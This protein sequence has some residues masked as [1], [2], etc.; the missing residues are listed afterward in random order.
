[1]RE[2]KLQGNLTQGSLLRNLM[3]FSI[4][5]LIACFLQTFYGLADLYIIGQ[6]HGASSITAVSVGSQVTH[7]LTVVIVGLAMG[8]T[9]TISRA[10]GAGDQKRAGCYIAHVILCSLALAIVL[11][12]GL[13]LG[14]DGIIRL[15]S[16]PKE[17]LEETREYLTICFLGTIFITAYNCIS[18]IFRGLGDSKRPMFFVAIAG[19]L[20]IVLD[21]YFIGICGFGARGAA[22]GT[23]ISQ[24]F[25]VLISG[26]VLFRMRKGLGL[27]RSAFLWN[28]SYGKEILMI[29]G[30]IALQDSFI[31]IS[32]LIITAIANGRGVDTAAAVGIVEKVIG[33]AFLVPSAMLSSVSAIA[34]Q[35]AGASHHDRARKVLYYGI[36]ICLGY[37]LVISIICQG[38]SAQVLELFAKT[39]P[40]VITLGSQYLRAYIWDCMFAGVHFCFSGYFTAYGKSWISFVHNMISIVIARIPLAYGASILFPGNLFPMGCAAPIGS[41]V[42]SGICIV[43]FLVF[44]KNQKGKSLE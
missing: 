9:V 30:P 17:A 37:G 34:A 8:G 20:N 10:I 31:Q 7:M 26:V 27:F 24:A 18:S 21:Y 40:R 11:T 25:S 39:E 1:M 33:F 14:T 28:A 35:N 29:G 41:I 22:L 32:F 5:Y 4:P 36:A 44:F 15:L 19:V 3:R 6:F 12:L 23:V 43:A 38:F 2:A 42:S 16:T 13:C